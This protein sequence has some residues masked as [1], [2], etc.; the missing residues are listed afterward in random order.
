LV[1]NIRSRTGTDCSA[2][3]KFTCWHA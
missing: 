1:E 3:G 2:V